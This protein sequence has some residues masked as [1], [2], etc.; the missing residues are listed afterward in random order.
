MDVAYVFTEKP[1]ANFH[2]VDNKV[3]LLCSN[4]LRGVKYISLYENSS[5]AQKYMIIIARF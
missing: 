4:L 2:I 3:F 5:T 1:A